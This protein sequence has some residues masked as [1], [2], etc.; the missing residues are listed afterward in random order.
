MPHNLSLLPDSEKNAIELDK[1]AA[2]LVWQ[3]KEG[4]LQREVIQ[5]QLDRIASESEKVIFSTSIEKY[6]NMM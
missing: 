6:Q 4:K 5:Q 2:Y 1:Q 3:I